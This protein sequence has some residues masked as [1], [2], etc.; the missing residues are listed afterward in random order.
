MGGDNIQVAIKAGRKTQ[1]GLRN[2]NSE[3]LPTKE[4]GRAVASLCPFCFQVVNIA[5]GM[6]PGKKKILVTF[7]RFF[8]AVIS[9]LSPCPSIVC[10]CG[11]FFSPYGRFFLLLCRNPTNQEPHSEHDDI[12][13]LCSQL[14]WHVR[15]HSRET[16]LTESE[17]SASWPAQVGD[18]SQ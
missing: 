14:Y 10:M 8:D 1:L 17:V 6:F 13:V 16:N 11:M 18:P 9:P 2:E 15:H 5:K 12:I 4:T 7:L 3:A